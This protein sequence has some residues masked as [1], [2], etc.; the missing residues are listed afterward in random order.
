ME[1]LNNLGMEMPTEELIALLEER[2][3]ASLRA[4]LAEFP[5]AD[6]ADFFG[7]IAEESHPLVYRILPK[8]TAAEVFVQMDSEAQERLILCFSDRELGEIL[9]ELYL[10][11][12]VDII[13]EMPAG[14]VARILKAAKPA[15]RRT[16]NQLLNYP[17]DSA[18]SLMTTEFVSLRRDMTV[19]EAFSYIRRVA[20][21]KETVY[22][23]YVTDG[24]RRLIGLVT[25]KDLLI[26]EPDRLIGDMMEENV[27]FTE[28]HADREDVA[29]LF[30]RY[31]FLALPVVD[32]EG[33]IVGIITVD[34]AVDV[35]RDA[36][37]EDF[38]KMAAI[39]P[40]DT[41]YLKTGVFAVFKTRIPWLMILML[42]ATLTGL[43]ITAFESALATC[44]VLTAF[45]PMLMGTGGNSGAQASVAVIR[46]LSL[47]EIER[48]DAG[49]VA[50][51]ELAV[52][53]LCGVSLAAVAFAKVLLVDRLL[54]ANPEVTV[55]VALAVALSLAVTVIVAKLI[56]GVLPIAA[57]RLGADPAV[58]ASPFITTIVDTLSLLVYFLIAGLLVPGL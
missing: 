5:P 36:A 1:E 15:D 16:I 58:M 25:V 48:G 4:R 38:A 20:P 27:I 57:A 33:R 14:V 45:I 29:N 52:S 24:A 3:Y 6:I 42:T 30:D 11:D 23:C 40:T 35:I 21:D 56:G 37:E 51:K 18:G 31:D 12:T 44:D 7:E 50:L 47:G 2:K 41:P 54:F 49:R 8:E 13:E 9:D 34:D 10:D 46:A 22:N 53:L 28:T 19:S 39:T 26:A 17:K 32:N 43:I 55:F